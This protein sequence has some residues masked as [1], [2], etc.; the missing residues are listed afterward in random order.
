MADH[1]T[2]SEATGGKSDEPPPGTTE[3][4]PAPQGGGGIKAWLPLIITVVV[5]P[6]L[7]YATTAFVLV[8]KMQKSLRASADGE[9][10]AAEEGHATE[11]SKPAAHGEPAKPK[12]KE[13]AA[14]GAEKDGA[15]KGTEKGVAKTGGKQ[16]VPLSSKILV[17]VASTMGSRYLVASVALVGTSAE[18]EDTIKES[19]PQLLDLA[20]GLLG[21]KTLGDL[22]KPGARNVIRSELLTVFNNALGAGTVKDIYITEFAVQ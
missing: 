13:A 18:F 2:T 12:E 6:A 14:H 16:T 19:D 17:N 10:V 9:A 20:A 15:K 5:M 22:E 21:S 1:P 4:T 3:A 8:P 11:A 7:A